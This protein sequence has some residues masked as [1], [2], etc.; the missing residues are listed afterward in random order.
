ML[1]KD[2]LEILVCIKCKKSLSQSHDDALDCINCNIS[3]PIRDDIPRL[4][5][6]EIID[7]NG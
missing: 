7:H 3:Y 6:S 4:V 2:I 1:D 5:E